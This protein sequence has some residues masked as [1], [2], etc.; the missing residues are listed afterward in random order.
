MFYSC[1]R[2]FIISQD[3]HNTRVHQCNTDVSLPPALATLFASRVQP[4]I[5]TASQPLPA[6]RHV[7]NE[8]KPL[9]RLSS[10]TVILITSTNCSSSITFLFPLHQPDAF[11]SLPSLLAAP[12]RPVGLLLRRADWRPEDQGPL[13]LQVLREGF[14]QVGQPDQTPEDSHWGAALQVQILREIVFNFL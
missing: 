12:A 8:S 5:S 1:H 10:I 9:L 7:Q 3:H 4:A 2:G 6:G 13:R 14:P 11:V